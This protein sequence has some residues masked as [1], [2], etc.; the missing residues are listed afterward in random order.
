MLDKFHQGRTAARVGDLAEAR[1]LLTIAAEE[2]PDNAEV[3]LELAGVVESPEEKKAC[4]EKALAL[5]PDNAQ[6]RASLVLLERKLTVTPRDGRPETGEELSGPVSGLRSPVE[7][8]MESEPLHC[9]R[10]PQV[11]TPLRCNRCNKPIC[12]KCAQRT[13]VGFRCPDCV[14]EI[15]DRYYSQVQG[16]YLLPYELPT[17]KPLFTYVFIG[18][19][20]LIWLA[21][22]LAGGSTNDDVLITFGA[23]YGPLILQGEIWRLFTSMFLHIGPQHLVFN[24]IGLL[25]FGFEM[26]RL[27][28]RS[29]YLTIYLLS[30]LFGSLASFAIRGPGTYSAGA[31][32]AIFGVVGM[33]AAFFLFYRRRLGEFGR[34]R[35][36]MALIL[37]GISLALGFSGI[38]PSDNWA[39]LGG[40]VAGFIFGY[41]LTPRY[42]VDPIAVSPRRVVDRGSLRRRWWVPV[43][44]IAVLIS[45]VWLAMHYWL[46]LWDLNTEPFAETEPA[47][48]PI[49]YG[50]TMTHQLASL[51]GDIW[52]FEGE[53]DQIVAISVNSQDLEP[54]VGLFSFGDKFLGEEVSGAERQ[55]QLKSVLPD[56]GT[57]TIYITSRDEELG[58]YELSL[59]LVGTLEPE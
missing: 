9:Y 6:A 44:G 26:E 43:L 16:N 22:E 21:Q 14:L 25:A 48:L 50:Q 45:G 30:G 33:Q 42:W 13:P 36:N 37:I 1:R 40:F 51:D 15:E 2:T 3:W 58:T 12:P 39:H 20:V 23:N 5:D 31:S 34:Q 35:R 54:Y 52:I 18:A 55:V 32:G 28:G 17:A 29:R 41:L 10:H 47:L 19:I 38:M 56:S 7:S 27:Y 4:L 46:T 24:C 59:T 8:A 49:E 53:A 57:Y 11:E